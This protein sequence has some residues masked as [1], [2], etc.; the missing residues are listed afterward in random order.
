MPAT[1]SPASPTERRAR[2][3]VCVLF[4]TNGALFANIVPRFPDI[5]ADLGLDNAI[6]GLAVT[7][8]PIGAIVSGLAAAPLIRTFGSARVA[9]LG[10]V[11]TSVGLFS[12]GLA[13]VLPLLIAGLFVAGAMDAFTDVA[14]NHHALRVQDRYGRSIINSFHA[15]WSLGAVL[16]G[17]MSA[18]AIA[19]GLSVGVHLAISGVAFSAVALV[20]YRFCLPGPEQA[21]VST[22]DSGADHAT[23]P[24]THAAGTDQPRTTGARIPFILAALVVVAVA[25]TV[26]E[27]AGNSWATLYLSSLGA[28]GAVAATGFI[29]LVAAQFVGRLVGDTLVDRYGRRTVAR[30]GGAVLAVGMGL[31]LAFPSVPGTVLGLAAAGFGVATLVPSA[32]QEASNLPGLRP[33]T[34]LAV[35]SWLMRIG[36]LAS[37]PIIG[38]VADATSLRAGLLLIP[39]AGIA[40]FAFSGVLRGREQG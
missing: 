28:P 31:A 37:P 7:A 29:T 20:A 9:V 4:L 26:V 40:V 11:L 33:G 16:G 32:M 3:A 21:D 19:A 30:A 18:G 5:K 10:T 39:V 25:G 36:F 17:T 14:Q 8:F 38:A 1:P 34:G 12:A 13:P 35:V 27:D 6:Y 24:A 23:D 2:A 15:V 22:A